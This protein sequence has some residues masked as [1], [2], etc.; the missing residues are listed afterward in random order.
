MSIMGTCGLCDSAT[1]AVE[2]HHYYAGLC[3]NPQCENARTANRVVE[4]LPYGIRVWQRYP[5]DKLHFSAKRRWI[6][7]YQ[8]QPALKPAALAAAL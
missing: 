1:L 8:V 4:R 5:I 2:K 7:G 6:W 3:A